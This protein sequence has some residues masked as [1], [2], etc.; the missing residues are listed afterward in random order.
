[1]NTMD[2]LT[3]FDRLEGFMIGLVALMLPLMT[4]AGML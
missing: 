4:V 3:F 1:M 2:N